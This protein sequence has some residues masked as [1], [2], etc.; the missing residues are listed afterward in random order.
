MPPLLFLFLLMF[1]ICTGTS[2]AQG[3]SKTTI[4][5]KP[6]RRSGNRFPHLDGHKM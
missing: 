1:R 6:V 3:E 4:P 2:F 5:C